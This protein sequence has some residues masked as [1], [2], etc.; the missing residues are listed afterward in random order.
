MLSVEDAHHFIVKYL[1]KGPTVDRTRWATY[2]YELYL[3]N[4]MRD[5]V[6]AQGSVPEHQVEGQLRPLSTFFY[7]A[8]WDLCRRGIIRPGIKELGLQATDDGA[9]GNGYSLTPFGREWLAESDRDDY[10]PTEPERFG[11]MLKPYHAKFGPGF[12]ERAQQAIRCYGAHAYLA[13]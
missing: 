12:Y 3:P 13:C 9:G 4:V 11:A 2:G 8:A 1:R 10:V 7:A 6:L 5:Y